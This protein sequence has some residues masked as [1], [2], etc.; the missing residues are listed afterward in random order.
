[1]KTTIP[2]YPRIGNNRELKKSCENYW[3]GKIPLQSLL[4]NGKNIR[5]QNWLLQQSQGIDIIPSNDFSFYDQVLDMTLTVG[6]IPHRYK[7]IKEDTEKTFF[8]LYFAMARGIQDE[9]HDA[10]AME[11]TK[12]FNTNYHYIVPELYQ[13]QEFELFSH[14]II[15]EFREAKALGIIT[16]PVIIGQV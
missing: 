6:N 14:K 10:V 1:M 11:M 12:W 9:H 8:D 4:D 5:K 15:D 13:D 3:I 2:G 7:K 16:K